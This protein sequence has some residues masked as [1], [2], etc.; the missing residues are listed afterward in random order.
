MNKR[1]SLPLG[2]LLSVSLL[3]LPGCWQ[4][5]TPDVAQ[6]ESPAQA[7]PVQS[8]ETAPEESVQ[9]TVIVRDSVG[10][11]IV[12]DA[13]F[14][15]ALQVVIAAQPQLG[16]ALPFLPKE[17]QRELYKNILDSYLTDNWLIKKYVQLKGLDQTAEAIQQRK[18]LEKYILITY[19][20][21]LFDANVA[22]S[23]AITDSQ[24]EKFYKDNR[25]SSQLF[26]EDV[27]FVKKPGIKTIAVAADNEQQA[28][29]MLAKARAEKDLFVAAASFN[30]TANELGFIDPQLPML[31]RPL[32][33][34][35]DSMRTFPAF[36]TVKLQNGAILVIQ[37]VERQQ[38]EYT[39][40]EQVKEEVK[41]V[42]L[43]QEFAK[44]RS[45][46]LQNL[47]KEYGVEVLDT[48][49]IDNLLREP[50]AFPGAQVQDQGQEAQPA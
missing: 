10:T 13:D 36:T 45:E 5:S 32:A 44:K 3:M 7:V 39:P 16:Q 37:G 21:Q 29:E 15:E 20:S 23:I 2:M 40:F 9:G 47:R 14:Q 48:T 22:D 46:I 43:N 41:R 26:T 8:A 18:Q 1:S 11:P 24:A 38:A 35:L 28:Q 50:I 33:K 12:T 31:E 30:K 27:F 34:A 19:N 4:T 6:Q 25:G 17:Q 49:Y 42:M